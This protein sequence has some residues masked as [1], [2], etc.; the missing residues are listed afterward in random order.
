MTDNKINLTKQRW[1]GVVFA[2]IAECIT[3]ILLVTEPSG[4]IGGW[5]LLN[6]IPYFIAVLITGHA[7]GGDLGIFFHI[8]SAIQWFIIGYFFSKMYYRYLNKD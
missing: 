2:V 3:I 8:S 1:V 5:V 6:L 4:L 7:H